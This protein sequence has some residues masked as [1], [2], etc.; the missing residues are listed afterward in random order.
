MITYKSTEEIKIL[1]EGGKILHQILHETATLA[2]P[3]VTTW[4]LDEVAE[5]AI[6]AA[7]GIPAFKHYGRPP[8]PATLC[9]SVNDAV[10]HGIPSKEV[11]LVEGDIISL[12]IGMKYPAIGGLYTDMA[13]TVP[14]GQIDKQTTKLLDV[15]QK[16]LEMIAGNIGPGVDWQYVAGLIQRYIEAHGFGIVRSMVG[17]GVGYEVHEDPQL[18]NYVIDDYHLILKEGMVLAFEPMVTM[19]DYNIK[20]LD[21]DWTVSTADGSLAAHFEHTMAITKNGVIVITEK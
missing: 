3:G 8:Y 17:H 19:G 1:R 4:K 21:D 2:Q 16:S 10:V 15:T 18:P 9:T 20:T 5:K 14:V 7:G 12:D 11:I 6:L 13:I